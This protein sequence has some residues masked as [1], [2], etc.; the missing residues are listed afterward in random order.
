MLNRFGNQKTSEDI[1]ET[2][3]PMY[4]TGGTPYRES[5]LKPKS[6]HSAQTGN[7]YQGQER[8]SSANSGENSVILEAKQSNKSG[9]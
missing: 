8:G 6:Q 4:S 2:Q 9:S 5:R 1:A 3:T 7:P